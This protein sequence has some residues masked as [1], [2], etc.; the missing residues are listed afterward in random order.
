[1]LSYYTFCAL[2]GGLAL[3]LENR[4]Y[5][6][7]ALAVLGAAALLVLIWASRQPA[8]KYTNGHRNT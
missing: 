1:V 7:I 3:L 8:G 5:K 6:V 2:F 4:L